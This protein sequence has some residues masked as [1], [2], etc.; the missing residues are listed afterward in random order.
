MG[1]PLSLAVKP[2][3]GSPQEVETDPVLL[4]D[5]SHT[6]CWSVTSSHTNPS[7]SPGFDLPKGAIALES[8]VHWP[9]LAKENAPFDNDLASFNLA[10]VSV[11]NQLKLS[12]AAA[13]P[14]SCASGS[15][16]EAAWV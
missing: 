6:S 1:S 4:A 7:T 9:S 15:F 2:L 14:Q 3:R 11:A 8:L 16:P 5:A 10:E 12:P 13:G